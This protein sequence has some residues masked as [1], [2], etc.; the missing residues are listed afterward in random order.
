MLTMCATIAMTVSMTAV[1][2]VEPSR[3]M[4]TNRKPIRMRTAPASSFRAFTFSS[5]VLVKLG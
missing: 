3:V 4:I 5:F 2:R 1:S